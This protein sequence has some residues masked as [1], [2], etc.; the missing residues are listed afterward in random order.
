MVGVDIMRTGTTTL[1]KLIIYS[2]GFI[3]FM[4]CVFWLPNMAQKI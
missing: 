1:L 4:F 3:G 2:I